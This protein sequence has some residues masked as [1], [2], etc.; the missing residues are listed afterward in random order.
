MIKGYTKKL[1]N[2][3]LAQKSSYETDP[4]GAADKSLLG[5]ANPL[6]KINGI[7]HYEKRYMDQISKGLKSPKILT[8][9]E[10]ENIA[11][12]LATTNN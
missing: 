4:A 8:N 7:K 3:T 9:I 12:V 2:E 11:Q 6:N 10:R 5:I 1:K